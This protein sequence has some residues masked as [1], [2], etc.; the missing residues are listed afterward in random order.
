MQVLLQVKREMGLH[1]NSLNSHSSRGNLSEEAAKWFFFLWG[2]LLLFLLGFKQVGWIEPFKSNSRNTFMALNTP[3]TP[4]DQ[5]Q[6]LEWKYEKKKKKNVGKSTK[7]LVMWVFFL[8]SSQLTPKKKQI[9]A[10]PQSQTWRVDLSSRHSDGRRRN[11]HL[12]RRTMHLRSPRLPVPERNALFSD[13]VTIS[14]YLRITSWALNNE[15]GALRQSSQPMKK[16]IKKVRAGKQKLFF[17][18]LPTHI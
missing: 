1:A 11:T 2:T 15:A 4:A 5:S 9:Q 7:T 18:F 14:H 10:F 17:F 8:L 6:I 13:A 3:Y 16:I 12:S